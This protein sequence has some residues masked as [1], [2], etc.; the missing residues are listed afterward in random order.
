MV[1]YLNEFASEQ[2]QVLAEQVQKFR[3]QPIESMREVAATSADGIKSLKAPVRA[4]AHSG[5]KLVAISQNAMQNL[6][7]LESEVVTSALTAAALR[8]ERAAA[9]ENV[10]Y[11]VIEQAEM[12]GATRDRVADEVARA[13]EIF[14][15]AGREVR[16]VGTHLYG[17]VFERAEEVPLKAKGARAR[18]AKRAVRKSTTRA[19]KAAA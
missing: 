9:A 14:R 16:K 15:V 6:I 1:A 2:R 8:L 12:L 7:E 10:V 18:K 13:V 17:Q 4:F 5:V 19:R 3:E 11:L